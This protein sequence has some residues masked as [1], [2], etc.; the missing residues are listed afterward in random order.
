MASSTTL[1]SL[2]DFVVELALMP[3]ADVKCQFD[4]EQTELL[5][6]LIR[7]LNRVFYMSISSMRG[8]TFCLR[9]LLI[10]VLGRGEKTRRCLVGF[11]S[12]FA[13]MASDKE[14]EANDANPETKAA[15]L[16]FAALLSKYQQVDTPTIAEPVHSSET[17][18]P[19]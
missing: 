14:A 7:A 19:Q 4:H 3:D 10:S 13:K 9:T 18:T 12:L 8:R 6:G 16:R 5:N 15:L 17:P 11:G 1:P 2:E